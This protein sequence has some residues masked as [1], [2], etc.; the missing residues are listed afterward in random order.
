[1]FIRDSNRRE[2]YSTAW[3]K[4]SPATFGWSNIGRVKPTTAGGPPL[5]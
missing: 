4:V 5:W 2:L 3:A 1:L